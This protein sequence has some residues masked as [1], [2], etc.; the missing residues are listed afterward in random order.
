VCFYRPAK[1]SLAA[2]GYEISENGD[3][4]RLSNGTCC[5]V[6]VTPGE[7][8]FKLG[9]PIAPD[10]FCRIDAVPGQQYY[11]LCDSEPGVFANKPIFQL[12]E[13]SIGESRIYT[14]RQKQ[15]L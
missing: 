1:D 4:A 8:V 9:M 6:Y 12:V 2:R 3:V 15:P 10:A 7:H 14:L 5:F 13:R 11:I